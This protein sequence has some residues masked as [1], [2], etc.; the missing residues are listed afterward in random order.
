MAGEDI[1]ALIST[2]GAQAEAGDEIKEVGPGDVGPT[3]S[4]KDKDALVTLDYDEALMTRI[5]KDVERAELRRTNRETSWDLLLNEF[6]PIVSESGAAETVKV[7]AHF[8]N[9][10]TKIGALFFR[11]PD[12]I[13]TPDDP[14]PGNNTKPDP[15][16]MD[17]RFQQMG[18]QF[19]PLKQE[20][21]ISLKQAV[22]K[23]KLGRDGIKA[24]RLMDEMLFDVLQWSG[25]G[26]CKIGYQCTTRQMP[27]PRMV[28]DPNALPATQQVGATLA[29]NGAPPPPMVQATDPVTGELLTDLEEVPIYEEWYGRRFSPKKFLC[30]PNLKSTRVD[31]DA[32]W[33]GMDFFLT[34][35]VASQRF[36]IPVAELNKG[37]EDERVHQWDSDSGAKSTG[38][39]HCYEMWM[40]SSYWTPK[41]NNHPLAI[42]Q[43]VLI[44][45]LKTRPAVWRPSP[46]QE[47]DKAGRITPDSLTG[48]PIKVLTIRDLADSCFPP[49]DAAFTNSDIKQMS[50]WRRQSV[51]IRDAAVGKYLYDASAFG[52]DEVE[53]LK[54]GDIGMFIPVQDG[55]MK[56]GVDK[57]FAQTSK[58]QASADDYRGFQGIKQD[59]Q[60]T[61]GIGSNQAG[62]E[63]DTVRTA[64][65]A[66]KVAS[67]VQAR[68]D[69]ELGRVIDFYL[70]IARGIDQL[71]MRYMTE[72]EYVAI[73][74]DEA[75]QKM[76]VWNGKTITG[77]YLYDIAPDSQL[78]P[79]NARDERSLDQYYNLT[80]KDPFSNRMYVLRRMARMRGLDPSKATQVPPQT[81]PKME[82]LKLSLSLTVADLRDPMVIALLDKFGPNIDPSV[83]MTGHEQTE[84]GGPAEKGDVISQHQQSNSGGKQNAPGAANHREQQVK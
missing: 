26:C 27:V 19:P 28:P 32:T 62:T 57:V 52:D 31:E 23:K 58:V 18:Q 22:L 13:L 37:A 7:Q 45:G 66:D 6:M 84:H 46:D 34:P 60:E 70:D 61:L 2:L 41:A 10:Q 75:G 40:K 72:A 47:F 12:L 14:G 65:E 39:V 17:P 16:S 73:G 25:I 82:P 68:N 38:L 69:K 1:S 36:G 24:N 53:Q 78:R 64:T 55:R 30:D 77:K 21:I 76:A 35:E 56:D 44:K 11:S 29:L 4:D 67:A 33:D 71:L 3:V 74:G 42:N 81:P 8:R 50:T 80:A 59:M 83:K 63:T 51:Q 49:S 15:R 43:L 48:F 79:D 5:W 54:N 20:D 9:T